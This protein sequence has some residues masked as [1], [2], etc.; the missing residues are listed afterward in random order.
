MALN[1]N[2][3]GARIHIVRKKFSSKPLAELLATYGTIENMQLQMATEEAEQIINHFVTNGI[4]NVTVQTTG[5]ALA[6][7]GAGTGTIS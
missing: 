1:K 6:Q 3:L 5:T 7:A 4:V 2:I